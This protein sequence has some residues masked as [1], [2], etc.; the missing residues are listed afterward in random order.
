MFFYDFNTIDYKVKREGVGIKSITGSKSQLCA[1][2]LE[3]G[4]MTAHQHFEEQIGYI[5]SGKVAITI[6]VETRTLGPGEGYCI[7][8]NTPHEFSVGD[9]PVEYIEVFCPPKNENCM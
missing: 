3:P 1:I 9:E 8:G 6:N 2:K 4:V 7:P 5:L